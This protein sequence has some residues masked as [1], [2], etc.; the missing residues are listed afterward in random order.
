MTGRAMPGSN[1]VG[2]DI[3]PA[4]TVTTLG[5]IPIGCC[6]ERSAS[7][8]QFVTKIPAKVSPPSTKTQNVST[9]KS[10]G[11]DWDEPGVRI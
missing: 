6:A 3:G 1:T 4:P 7:S 11:P 8:R 10:G 2:T 9:T 5:A